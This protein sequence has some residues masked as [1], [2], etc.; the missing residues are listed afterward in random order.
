MYKE[1]TV[2]KEK[3]VKKKKEEEKSSKMNKTF[4]RA[5]EKLFLPK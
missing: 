4:W 1:K 2:L 3:K 5:Y